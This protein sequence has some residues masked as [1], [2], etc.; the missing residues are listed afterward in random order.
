M[1]VVY[2]SSAGWLLD[3]LSLINKWYQFGGGLCTAS[4]SIS[5]LE[6]KNSNTKTLYSLKDDLFMVLKPYFTLYPSP[7]A[8]EPSTPRSDSQGSNSATLQCKAVKKKRK[9]SNAFNQGELDALEYHKKISDLILESSQLLIQEGFAKGLLQPVSRTE[10]EVGKIVADVCCNLA[11]LCDMAKEMPS[12]SA[13]AYTVNVLGT[14]TPVEAFQNTDCLSRITENN[15]NWPQLIHL[16][17]EKYLMPPKSSF[18]LSDI[19]YMEPL[20]H[21]KKYNIIVVDPPWENKSV[22]R[23]KRYSSLTPLEIKQLPIPALAAQNCLVVTWVTNRQ[24]HLR[25]VK[26]EL[27]PHWSIRTLAEWHWVKITRSGEFVFPIHSA[28][29]KPYEIMVLGRLMNTDNSAARESE[30]DVPL[31]PQH[32]IIVSVPCK[33]HSHKPPLTEVLKEYVKQDVEYL[34]LFARNLQPGWTSWGNEVLKFQHVDYFI[35]LETGN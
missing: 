8:T 27:Y 32:K 14:G 26:E 15:S 10:E 23:S 4:A 28:H 5:H 1:A 7:A 17:G 24:K 13:N 29:K 2:E 33:L 19:S 25:F 6:E 22:K 21:Y 11:E 35:P 20:L 31:F 16:M 3:E 30:K 34:E 12:M 18:L 9:R